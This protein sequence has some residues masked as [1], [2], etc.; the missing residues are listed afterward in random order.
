MTEKLI[1]NKTYTLKIDSLCGNGNGVARHNGFV[2]FV[3]G[4]ACGDEIEAK[5]IK[6]TKSYAVGKCEKII[7]ASPDRASSGCA[8]CT[9]CGGCSFQHISYAAECDIKREMIND[10]FSRIGGLD[11]RVCDFLGAN[12]DG[13]YRNKAMYPVAYNRDGKLISGFY[14]RMSHRIVEH[15]DCL[16][17]PQIFAQIKNSVLEILT[18]CAVPAYDELT[19]KGVIR[20]IYMRKNTMDRVLLTLIVNSDSL[21]SAAEARICEYIT[22]KHPCVTGILLNVNR[23]NGNSLL[24]D[25]W[26]TLWGDDALYDTL[27]GKKFRIAPAAFYQ[28]NHDQTE[29]LYN[30]AK[31]F[32]GIR[33]GDVVFDLY[34]GTGTIGIILAQ[35]GVKLVGVEISPDA[36]RDAAQNAAI[37]GVDAEFIC[38]DA[39]EA[40]DTPR[41]REKH[42]DVIVIDPPRKGC[43]P[44]AA[45]KIA[46]FGAR[47]VVYISCDPHTLARDLVTFAECGYAAQKAVGV[48]LFPRTGHVETVVLL[49]QLSLPDG[50]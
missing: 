12:T 30:T 20:C 38:L 21:G 8:V 17:G 1:K 47:T 3:P 34:C 22:E 24:G 25:T 11:L 28:V 9:S 33:E 48:D 4:T 23:K 44:D 37:N 6:V 40:L 50:K 13:R 7:T 43:G 27:C 46:A 14:A 2:V 36:V 39:D 5:I 18:E 32:A 49:Q 41:L 19:G 15:D 31:E 10:S 16:I 35:P 45:K 26:R 29:R 42:P